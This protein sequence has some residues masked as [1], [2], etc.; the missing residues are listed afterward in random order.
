MH[1][2]DSS[3]LTLVSRRADM[4]PCQN[5]EVI[6]FFGKYTFHRHR[7]HAWLTVRSSSDHRLAGACAAAHSR[8]VCEGHCHQILAP[9]AYRPPGARI[10]SVRLTEYI[11]P[12]CDRCTGSC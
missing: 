12:Q 6:A 11:Q 8:G 5:Y 3:P 1:L 9:T 4:I 7:L 2:L 10:C